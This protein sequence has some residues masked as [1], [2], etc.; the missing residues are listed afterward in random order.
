MRATNAKSAVVRVLRR[1]A[2]ADGHL[3]RPLQYLLAESQMVRPWFR[4]VE[5]EHSEST[6]Q[7]EGSASTRSKLPKKRYHCRIFRLDLASLE[8]DSKRR[9]SCGRRAQ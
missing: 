6:P 1:G 4:A 2:R 8:P 7:L 9:S 5:G 3:Q